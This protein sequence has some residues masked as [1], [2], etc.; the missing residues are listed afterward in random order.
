MT[1]QKA[2]WIT[3]KPE[4]IKAKII[5]LATQGMTSEKIGLVLRDQHGIPRAKLLGV[6]IKAVLLEAGLWQD[7]EH[8]A[9]SNKVDHLSKHVVKHKHDY[10][11]KRSL[12]R[13]TVRVKKLSQKR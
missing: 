2:N 11:G 10:K 5:D 7:G 12:V 1:E 9:L 8:R 3:A 13:N 4:E 6:R